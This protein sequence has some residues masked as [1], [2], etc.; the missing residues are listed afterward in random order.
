[1]NLAPIT[2]FVY[3]RLWHTQQT[4][5]ALQKNELASESELFIYADGVKNEKLDDQ[6]LEVRS[7][8]KEVDG[9][10]CLTNKAKDCLIKEGCNPKKITVF[11]YGI[12]LKQF[13][14]GKRTE[15][16][17]KRLSNEK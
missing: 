5:E 17:K 3:N 7:Y 11:P 8:I 12:D 6:V 15:K 2:L 14:P 13:K 9:F 1:M 10:H 4:I 16:E